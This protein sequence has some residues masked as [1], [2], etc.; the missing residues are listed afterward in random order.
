M[1]SFF[2]AAFLKA[3]HT[4]YL[5]IQPSHVSSILSSLRDLHRMPAELIP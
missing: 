1:Q 4:L 2:Y 3:I 5:L